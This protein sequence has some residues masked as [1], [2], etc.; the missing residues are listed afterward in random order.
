MQAPNVSP[1]APPIRIGGYTLESLFW[2]FIAVVVVAVVLGFVLW[3]WLGPR[4]RRLR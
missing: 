2:G 4:L 3:L 1:Q